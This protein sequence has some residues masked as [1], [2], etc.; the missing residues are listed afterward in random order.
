MFPFTFIIKTRS[1]DFVHGAGDGRK[2]PS[3]R[4]DNKSK[5]KHQKSIPKTR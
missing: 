1:G 3:A 4:K 2:S 5:G